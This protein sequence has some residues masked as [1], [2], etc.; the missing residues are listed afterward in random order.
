MQWNSTLA[1]GPAQAQKAAPCRS[2]ECL[3]LNDRPIVPGYKSCLTTRTKAPVKQGNTWRLELNKEF[4]E[5]L[6]FGWIHVRGFERPWHIAEVNQLRGDN[7][8][9]SGLFFDP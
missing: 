8:V 1:P 5:G 4:Y 6:R 7:A 9:L 3:N 2:F